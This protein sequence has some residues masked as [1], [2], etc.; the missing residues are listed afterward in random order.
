MTTEHDPYDLHAQ[1]QQDT[2]RSAADQL[3]RLEE[4]DDIK[5]LMSSRR[6]RR[7]VWRWFTWCRVHAT[8][9]TGEALGS[10]YQ[11]GR[12]SIGLQLLMLIEEVSPGHYATMLEEHGGKHGRAKRTGGG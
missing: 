6:G 7:I 4:L 1:E 9:F 8:T 3:A 5:W 12:R 2:E 11:E 10:A